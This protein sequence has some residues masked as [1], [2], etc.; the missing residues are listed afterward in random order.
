MPAKAWPRCSLH[1]WRSLR[2]ELS[3]IFDAPIPA[4]VSGIAGR[5]EGE[6]SA[7]LVREGWAR[8][9]G[10]GQAL[11]AGVGQW[12]ICLGGEFRQ[13]FSPDC[14]MLSIRFHQDWPGG[15]PL[16]NGGPFWVL[17]AADHPRLERLADQILRLVGR[18]ADDLG[19]AEHDRRHEFLGKTRLNFRQ[20]A[21]YERLL[22]DWLVTFADALTSEGFLMQ[23][24]HELDPRV[25]RAV[26]V[27]DAL[28]PAADFPRERLVQTCGLSMGRLN[29]LFVESFARTAHAYWAD[30]RFQRARLSLEQP[31]ARVKEIAAE[32][33]F[34]QLSHFSSW[35]K[36]R[37]G[38]SPRE[39]RR[40]A[41]IGAAR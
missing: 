8:L 10:D 25:V 3:F 1:D 21:R 18:R 13:R 30:R 6:F 36:Q 39:Y 5:R 16:F 12:L 35:F 23:T 26:Q 38:L 19:L 15:E 31:Q 24:P 28:P 33:G 20:F 9:D 7:W 4:T 2:S 41:G 37:A 11:T 14:R 27:L 17:E 22:L 40:Q 32:L 34:L 29:R